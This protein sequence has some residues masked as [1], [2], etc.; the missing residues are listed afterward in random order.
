MT[1]ASRQNGRFRH[2]LSSR[3]GLGCQ[4]A[5]PSESR[6]ELGGGLG[7]SLFR[8][9]LGKQ[10][11]PTATFVGRRYLCSWGV[12]VLSHLGKQRLGRRANS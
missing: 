4:G 9:D 2:Q 7:E 11:S 3:L 6:G 5:G 1:I 10:R 8:T 12:V